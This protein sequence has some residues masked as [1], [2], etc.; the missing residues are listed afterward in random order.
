MTGTFMRRVT[1]LIVSYAHI[2]RSV[3]VLRTLMSL[4]IIGYNY[5]GCA[6]YNKKRLSC[7]PQ[8]IQKHK[9]NYK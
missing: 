7:L 6:A 2:I 9:G 1:R 3:A 8:M 4:L 5:L